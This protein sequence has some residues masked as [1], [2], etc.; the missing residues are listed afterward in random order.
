MSATFQIGVDG[1]PTPR[2]HGEPGG[3]HDEGCPE[4]VADTR[5]AEIAE[6]RE[7]LTRANRQL[8]GY[9]ANRPTPTQVAA[10]VEAAR[11]RE[12]HTANCRASSY[13]CFCGSDT[14]SAALAPF[15][16]GK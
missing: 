10:L 4:A 14:L 1:C 3:E 11:N 8:L 16:G 13:P 12:G 2:C 15:G 6:L 5:D 9:E 7:L